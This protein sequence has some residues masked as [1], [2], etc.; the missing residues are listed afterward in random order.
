MRR[1]KC[2]ESTLT[3]MTAGGEAGRT[4]GLSF[5]LSAC[6][7]LGFLVSRLVGQLVANLPPSWLA[8]DVRAFVQATQKCDG[9][10]SATISPVLDKL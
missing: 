8:T 4:I 6:L 10:H 3:T 5:S 2:S 1:D 9:F 7:S